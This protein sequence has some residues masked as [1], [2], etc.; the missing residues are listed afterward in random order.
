[1]KANDL[2]D[3][4]EPRPPPVRRPSAPENP[5]HGRLRKH[6]PP[7]TISIIMPCYNGAKHVERSILSVQAQTRRDWELIVV[8]DGSTDGSWPLLAALSATD[9]RIELL[10]QQNAGAAAARNRG[11]RA[12]RGRFIAFLDADDTWDPR[13]LELMSAA[14]DDN[15]DAG[16]AYCGWQNVGLPGGQGLPFIPPDYET[17]AKLEALLEGCRWPIHGALTRA[18]LIR[19]CDGF[20]ETLSSCMDYDLWLR[21]GTEQR[22]QR[23]PAVLAYYH[24][25]DGDQ[26]TRNL[27]R[28][29]LNHFRT[30]GKFL[31]HRPEVAHRLGTFR[32]RQLTV[33]ELLRRGYA[34]YWQ[35]DLPAARTIFC[36]VMRSG[37]GTAKDWLH[38]LPCLL[39]LCVHSRVLQ[40]I[41][42]RRR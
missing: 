38:M 14:L 41:D 32:V 6:E 13:F 26:I 19:G 34:A 8:D 29:A 12:A 11:L 36:V 1:M 3:R 16:I 22:L 40:Y 30:Q 20:D 23:I 21:L 10:R 2:R 15:P 37:Y 7:P 5:S 4:P 28:I 9:T 35:R 17:P 25:H 24:H 31:E 39:P 33:G 18:P 42:S 27:A